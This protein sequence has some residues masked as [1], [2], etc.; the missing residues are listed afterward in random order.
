MG[1]T[2]FAKKFGSPVVPAFILRRP[3]GRHK[4][5][6]GKPMHFD[7][8]SGDTDQELYDM[9]VEMTRILERVI[10]E[11]PTQWLWFQHRWNTPPEQRHTKHHTV[12]AL[13]ETKDES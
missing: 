5:W 3:D 12:K 9:T 1:R 6:L 7:K 8:S 4:V 10:R 11:N 13:K 2:R